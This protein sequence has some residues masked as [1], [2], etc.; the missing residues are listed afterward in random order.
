MNSYELVPLTGFRPAAAHNEGMTARFSQCARILLAFYCLGISACGDSRPNEVANSAP[1]RSSV[2]A[3]P[4][5]SKGE[6]EPAQATQGTL[7]E[8]VAADVD[9]GQ[10]PDA[11][12]EK[13]QAIDNPEKDGWASEAFNNKAGLQWKKVAALLKSQSEISAKDITAL[14]AKDFQCAGLLPEGQQTDFSD[15]QFSV[16]RFE[17][18]ATQT[19]S[20]FQ[21]TAGFAKALERLAAPHR[22]HG[23]M[24]AK[25]KI[26]RVQLE[27]SSVTTQQLV[28][29][30]GQTDSGR[31][32]YHALWI[33]RWNQPLPWDAPI[34]QE[35]VVRDV[36]LSERHGSASPL[37]VDCTNYCLPEDPQLRRQL[38]RGYDQW[39]DRIQHPWSTLSYTGL[40]VG[41]VNG[42]GL[43]DLYLTQEN[44]LPNRLFLQQ[45][46]GTLLEV[47]E[48]WKVN[49]LNESRGALLIDLDN[50]GDNDLAI[51]MLGG[52]VIAENVAGQ[53]FRVVATLESEVHTTSLAAADFDQ[54]GRLDIYVCAYFPS[55]ATDSDGLTPTNMA[56]ASAEVPFDANNGGSNSLFRNRVS[57]DAWMFEDV[58][59]AVGLMENNHRFSLAS[60]W[61]DFD[62]DGDQDLYVANDFGTNCLYR[63]DDGKF[64]DIAPSHGI[65][66]AGFGMS[67]SWSD[68]D[69]DQDMDIYV[70]NMFS[71]AGN[72]VTHQSKFKSDAPAKVRRKMQKMA[73]GNTLLNNQGEQGFVDVSDNARVTMGRW[74]WSS[75][76]RDINNDGWD[77]LLIANGFI[78]GERTDDL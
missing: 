2:T 39:L 22:Q 5:S 77:D 30:Y 53:R 68:Y 42:D 10:L 50:D 46:D 65:S 20:D 45:R 60:A 34:L 63:N 4:K 76:F 25:F 16:K 67:V 19:Q 40:A 54:D 33:A 11:R 44:G 18:S 69:R 17:S 6:S 61:E 55:S 58:T 59:E 62:N 70:G 41:D 29:L 31:R 48:Q 13:W 74:A 75:L 1:D 32:E 21:G 66:D 72:R 51:A 78:T 27:P 52:V 57:D 43:E 23:G 12:E 49:W 36:E 14:V 3:A 9:L 71:S 37:L 35:L 47:S 7:P 15:S 64:T 38:A 28:S 56:L 73:R 8:F 26:I 24:K